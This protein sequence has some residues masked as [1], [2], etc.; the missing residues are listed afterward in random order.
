MM[1][2]RKAKRLVASLGPETAPEIAAEFEALGEAGIEALLAALRARSPAVR[3]GAARILGQFARP[4]T[5]VPLAAL[6]RDGCA[7]ATSAL[8]AMAAKLARPRLLRSVHG[9]ASEAAP[10]LAAMLGAHAEAGEALIAMGP[11]G[12]DALALAFEIDD[13]T[14]AAGRVLAQTGAAGLA[15]LA[16]LL[17]HP[18][19]EV[20]RRAA[21]ALEASGWRPANARETAAAAIARADWKRCAEFGTNAV[22]PL[23]ACVSDADAEIRLNAI[24]TLGALKDSRAVAPLVAALDDRKDTVR[25]AGIEALGAIGGKEAT[26]ALAVRLRSSYD[27]RDAA[28]G[29]LKKTGWKPASLPDRALLA[30]LT[31]DRTALNAPPLAELLL[32]CARTL[33]YSEV[34][35]D[36]VLRGLELLDDARAKAELERRRQG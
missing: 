24:R 14:E 35:E 17:A 27:L 3:Q 22:E 16:R 33:D 34:P 20:R 19:K 8:A 26:A 13:L 7:E 5:L 31:K 9:A 1:T 28:L 12:M 15:V 2:G 21:H 36:I 30:V 18:R 32:R 29:A 4:A 6:A 25:R 23:I 11:P 10:A